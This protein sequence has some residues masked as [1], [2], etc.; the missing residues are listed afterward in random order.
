MLPVALRIRDELARLPAVRQVSLAGSIRRRKE[1]IGDIDLLASSAEPGTVMDAF[2]TL[3][4][5]T[6]VLGKGS[7]KS[8]IILSPGVQVDLRVVTEAQYWTALQY[9]TGSKD[10]N[11]N[12]RRRA[13]ERGWSLSEYGVK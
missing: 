9:F 6:R 11:I 8:S 1:T 4:E 3:P 7:T 12:L 2:C 13:L 5:V 10:H